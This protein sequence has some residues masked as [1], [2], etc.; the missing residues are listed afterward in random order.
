[1]A[2]FTGTGDNLLAG[3]VHRGEWF[4]PDGE[5]GMIHEYDDGELIHHYKT[6]EDFFEEEII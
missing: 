3:M 5:G 1:M 4:Y 2:G 6:I